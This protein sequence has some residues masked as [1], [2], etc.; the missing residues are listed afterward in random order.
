M[1]SSATN[2][3]GSFFYTN[4][5]ELFTLTITGS[6]L[7]SV[8][9]QYN[10]GERGTVNN[11]VVQRGSIIHLDGKTKKYTVVI[12]TSTF[13][14]GVTAWQGGALRLGSTSSTVDTTIK[15]NVFDY[16]CG[17]SGGSIFCQ[18]CNII[19][20]ENNNFTNSYAY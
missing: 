1:Q 19:L 10:N 11:Q 5:D 20:W 4:Y 8:N 2:G 14:N 3:G 18:N 9:F 6:S 13:K 17:V 15:G 16:N 12:N 7:S